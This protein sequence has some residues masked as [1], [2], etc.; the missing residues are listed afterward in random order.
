MVEEEGVFLLALVASVRG[1]SH[2]RM[3]VHPLE[4]WVVGVDEAEP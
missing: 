1:S 2:Q 4:R 3:Q